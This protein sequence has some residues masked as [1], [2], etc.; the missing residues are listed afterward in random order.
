MNKHV[1]IDFFYFD[2]T[3]DQGR[4]LDYILKQTDDWL[5]S[6][7]D[8]IQWLFP[9]KTRSGANPDAP[10]IDSKLF[11][12]FKINEIGASHMLQAFDRMLR[13]YG[14]HREHETI[15]KGA[16]WEY[17][18]EIWFERPTHNDLRITRII[19]SLVNL[20][21]EKYAQAFFDALLK[22]SKEP[23][24]GFSESAMEYWQSARNSSA[25]F[26]RTQALDGCKGTP[27]LLPNTNKYDSQK[28]LTEDEFELVSQRIQKFEEEIQRERL[29]V[30][31]YL[32]SHGT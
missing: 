15:G 11:V 4:T 9:L 8:F 10:L 16:N 5:E 22:L 7:H 28:P 2:G 23:E 32:I 13:F 24:C 26:S 27:P 29:E 17:R 6:T 18:K 3:D 14:L 19:G 1:L 31:E 21:Q 20:G 30:E 25:L 12:A